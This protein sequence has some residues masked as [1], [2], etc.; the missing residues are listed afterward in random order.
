M[1]FKLPEA[2]KCVKH[3]KDVRNACSGYVCMFSAFSY[4]HIVGTRVYIY[5]L[6]YSGARWSLSG[7]I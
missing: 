5:I 2:Y 1:K 7:W 4:S 6:T 3:V